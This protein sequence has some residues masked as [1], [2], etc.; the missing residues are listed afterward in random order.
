MHG[1]AAA[2]KGRSLDH[3]QAV[4]VLGQALTLWEEAEGVSTQARD[5][6]LRVENPHWLWG[7]LM[8][9]VIEL[10]ILFRE[11]QARSWI[12]YGGRKSSCGWDSLRWAERWAG[13]WK[14][15]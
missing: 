8:A 9:W 1:A 14:R 6:L 12:S 10:C 7:G 13:S 5:H 4:R 11:E 15:T 2:T 3:L